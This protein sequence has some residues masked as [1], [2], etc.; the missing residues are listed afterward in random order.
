[1]LKLATEA[2]FVIYVCLNGEIFHEVSLI[3]Q[4]F[5][6]HKVLLFLLNHLTT[7]PKRRGSWLRRSPPLR[8]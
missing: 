1:H 6:Q 4:Y 3:N 8:I 2:R 7:S 5:Q